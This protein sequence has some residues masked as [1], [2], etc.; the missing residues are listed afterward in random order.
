M[1]DTVSPNICFLP[2]RRWS[3]FPPWLQSCKK[4]ADLAIWCII[5]WHAWN[6]C[7]HIRMH[8]RGAQLFWHSYGVSLGVGL[9][10]LQGVGWQQCELFM[11]CMNVPVSTFMPDTEFR[12]II[13]MSVTSMP[14]H[15]KCWEAQ[16]RIGPWD[17]KLEL[18]VARD[19]GLVTQISIY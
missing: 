15:A 9:Q 19:L 16:I 17:K 6:G 7:H 13:C 18:S 14:S 12:L 11:L 10:C 3:Q 1:R 8:E 2:N 4:Y 5:L